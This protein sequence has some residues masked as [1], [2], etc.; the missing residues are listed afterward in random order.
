MLTNASTDKTPQNMPD[1]AE[2]SV[3]DELE[4][5]GFCDLLT[6]VNLRDFLDMARA[7]FVLVGTSVRVALRSRPARVPLAL[8]VVE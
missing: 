7:E 1:R 2:A 3:E 5:M 8:L 4:P 6:R